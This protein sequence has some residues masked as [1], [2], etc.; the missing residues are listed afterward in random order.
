MIAKFAAPKGDLFHRR[1]ITVALRPEKPTIRCWTLYRNKVK[2][3]LTSQMKTETSPI[4][5]CCTRA[6]AIKR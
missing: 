6:R 4:R 3:V 2:R 1:F 5:F